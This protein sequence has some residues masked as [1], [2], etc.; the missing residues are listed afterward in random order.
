MKLT[1]EVVIRRQRMRVLELMMDLD[2]LS[3]WQP[4]VRSVQLLSGQSGQ[5]GARSRVVCEMRGLRLEMIETVVEQC[6]PEGQTLSYEGH[7]VTSLIENRFH[8]D[9]PEET[10]WVMQ[11]SL[12]FGPLMSFASGLV[13]DMVA[14]RNAESMRL[15]KLFA[16]KS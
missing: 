14:K 9:R 2:N 13:G 8:E 11:T 16:E 6:L 15:F 4:G 10:R 7:G 1:S 12:K 3:H 5:V